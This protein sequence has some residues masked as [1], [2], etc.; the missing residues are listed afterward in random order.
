MLLGYLA[1][2]CQAQAGA[3]CDIRLVW[4]HGSNIRKALLFLLGEK[5]CCAR[6][7]VALSCS[8]PR[9]QV[10]APPHTAN[11]T[12]RQ[13]QSRQIVDSARL[14]QRSRQGYAQAGPDGPRSR[15][16]TT[17]RRQNRSPAW[18]TDAPDGPLA[19]P[20]DLRNRSAEL[21]RSP[22]TDRETVRL[23]SANEVFDLIEQHFKRLDRPD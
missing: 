20:H 1:E 11:G 15:P 4:V 2:H 17:P 19:D 22:S 14:R 21:L 12:A 9:T 6:A 5:H 7:R 10:T 18:S 16:T 23:T 8:T 13:R 3:T